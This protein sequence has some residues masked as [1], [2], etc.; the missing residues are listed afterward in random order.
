MS[1]PNTPESFWR[2]VLR[3]EGCWL[4]QGGRQS[5]G[6]GSLG[7]HG[8]VVQA[9]RLAYELTYGPI[10][11]GMSVRHTCDVTSCCRP[12]HLLLGTQRDNVADMVARN[13]MRRGEQRPHAKLS[14]ESVR[15][16]RSLYEQGG[17]SFERL[18]RRFGVSDTQV[19]A[20][21]SRRKWRHL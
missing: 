13:R 11:P 15:Q 5:H 2:R 19:G 6:Y 3:S 17:W 9:H 21:I 16:I 1:R 4:W 14:A 20:I 18:A 7:W 10:P 12:D 8:R